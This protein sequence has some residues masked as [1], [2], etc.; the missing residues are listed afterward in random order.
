M[1]PTSSTA[2]ISGNDRERASRGTKTNPHR[3]PRRRY[4]RPSPASP[5]SKNLYVYASQDS[6]KNSAPPQNLQRKSRNSSP[7]ASWRMNSFRTMNIRS[8][9]IAG[10]PKFRGVQADHCRVCRPLENSLPPG[11]QM[12]IGG[13]ILQKPNLDSRIWQRSWQFSTVAVFLA[14]L[15]P[16]QETQSSLC[17]SWRQLRMA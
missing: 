1:S 9:P 13:G 8:F 15:F 16:I 6:S 4:R 2:A 7:A 11:Y 5:M 14:L 17:S 10:T 3:R 12:Q